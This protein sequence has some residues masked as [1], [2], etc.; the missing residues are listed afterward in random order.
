MSIHS[1]LLLLHLGS[2][3]SGQKI[4]IVELVHFT[5]SAW[6]RHISLTWRLA[7]VSRMSLFIRVIV[8]T[9]SFSLTSG[10][11]CSV[12]DLT[13]C[14]EFLTH[15]LLFITFSFRSH[16]MH[17]VDVAYCYA[18]QT[19]CLYVGH[20]GEPFNNG[21]INRV[22]WTHALDRG[23]YWHHLVNTIDHWMIC[24]L[25]AVGFMSDYFEYL[26]FIR[27]PFPDLLLVISGLSKRNLMELEQVFAGHVTF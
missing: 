17:C 22:A 3:L 26:L 13:S 25:C 18:C 6:K 24:A 21:W 27:L 23:A 2:L 15:L 9:S 12:C 7:L 8:N 16:C 20:M 4:Q 10:L 19:V 11:Y 14:L 1:F 5:A